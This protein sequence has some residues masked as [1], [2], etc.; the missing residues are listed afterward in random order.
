MPG[1]NPGKDM[2]SEENSIREARFVGW[3]SIC[4]VIIGG[5]LIAAKYVSGD[6]LNQ[7]AVYLAFFASVPLVTALAINRSRISYLHSGAVSDNHGWAERLGRYLPPVV[8]LY[9][10]YGIN[11]ALYHAD[12][13]MI[14][15]A[16]FDFSRRRFLFG[17]L[18]TALLL[19]LGLAWRHR[20]QTRP[21]A[22]T[23]AKIA[24]FVRFAFLGV[25]TISLF[26]IDIGH[27][28]LSYD[29]YVGPASAVALGAVPLVDVFSQYGLNY[30]LLTAGLKLMPWSMY[31]LSLIITALN[32]GYYFL[33]A[34]I[35]L[36]V[37]RDKSL[38][39]VVSAFFILFLISA[40][41][42]NS[43][44][45]PSAGA[46]RYLPSLVLLWTFCYLKDESAFSWWSSL[47]LSLS[48]L[49]SLEAL[50]FSAVTYSAY[51]LA[52]SL[53]ARPINFGLALKRFLSVGMLLLLPYVLLTVAYKVAL[54]VLP[55]YDIY[56][57][58]VG[59]QAT[60]SNWIVR[61]D[62]AIRTWVIFGFSYALALAYALF[63]S[64][65]PE[66]VSRRP[67]NYYAVMAGTAA[68]G[69]MQLSYY[70]ERAVTP[71]L[72]FIAFPL[73]I[74]FVLFIDGFAQR[75]TGSEQQLGFHHWLVAGLIVSTVIACGGVIGDR[76]FR[77]PFVLRSNGILLRSWLSWPPGGPGHGAGLV[78]SIREKLNQPVGFV[79]G[80]ES[81]V[82]DKNPASW[83]LI[84]NSPTT[85][86]DIAAYGL[87]RKWLNEKD[88]VF[89]FS[90]D[91]ACV[92]FALKKRNALGLTHP[93]VDDRSS[94][95]RE[96]AMRVAEGMTAGTIVMVG[97]LAPQSIETEVYTYL[98]QHWLL[99]QIDEGANLTVF[100]LKSRL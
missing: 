72:V 14:D 55:R 35:C 30:L 31:S 16:G 61:A 66:A 54:G 18:V 37:S 4:F 48:S 82:T 56:L 43:A 38:V 32:L 95:L 100:R 57:Q 28:S 92:L 60:S 87:I 96:K 80:N 24:S 52:I 44:Y 22:A 99:E 8:L 29:P 9:G 26:N 86:P 36:R 23:S 68:L 40:A 58:L 89:L 74:I 49:W 25:F 12:F 34:V 2:T 39:V 51:I 91:S 41:L 17:L 73:L 6:R 88:E 19:A 67:H 64:W 63:K 77:A 78:H 3:C 47:A 42:Y 7:I 70:A 93:M 71:V 45:T 59:T 15:S 33:V 65:K 5:A 83:Q 94:L 1:E 69:I 20:A 21:H 90:P 13:E 97:Y 84:P 46:M 27:D 50:I 53:R 98:K 85:D 79:L 81:G 11:R 76:F 75:L 62:P 10:L